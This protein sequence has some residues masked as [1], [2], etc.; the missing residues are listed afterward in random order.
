MMHVA[1]V[2]DRSVR[3]VGYS[4]PAWPGNATRHQIACKQAHTEQQ[5]IA[6]GHD[7]C[8]TQTRYK[9][10]SRSNKVAIMR[11]MISFPG[12][13]MYSA[14]HECPYK[15]TRGATFAQGRHSGFC[16]LR[17]SYQVSHF[18]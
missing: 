6:Q 5:D 16:G 14:S 10:V 18:S 3:G 12:P 8:R 7:S 1:L 17:L 4:E 2:I 15:I 9:A 13:G 11:T